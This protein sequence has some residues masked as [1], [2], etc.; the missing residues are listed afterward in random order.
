[1]KNRMS[2]SQGFTLIELMVVMVI[3][4]FLAIV[5][6]SLFF[7]LLKTERRIVYFNRMNN[8]I[9]HLFTD[10]AQDIRFANKVELQNFNP[11]AGHYEK[12]VMGDDDGHGNIIPKVIY[13]KD[14]DQIKVTRDGTTSSILNNNILADSFGFEDQADPEHL[15]LIYINIALSSPNSQNQIIKVDRESIISNINKNIKIESGNPFISITP[16]P[17]NTPRPTATATITPTPI[18]PT[19]TPSRTPT[20]TRP[21]VPTAT[22]TRFLTPTP[23]STPTPPP[24]CELV[25]EPGTW[26]SEAIGTMTQGKTNVAGSRMTICGSGAGIDNLRDGFQYAYKTNTNFEIEMTTRIVNWNP[27]EG[28]SKAGIMFRSSNDNNAAHISIFL[29]GSQGIRMQWR[30]NNGAD[31]SITGERAGN[32][33]PVWL[34]LIKIGN[35]ITGY[36]SY[37]STDGQNGTWTVVRTVDM[38]MGFNH[39]YGRAVTSSEDEQFASAIFDQTS[40]QFNA[41]IT[42]APTATPRPTNTATPTPRVTA[43]PTQRPTATPTRQVAPTSTPTQRPTATPTRIPSRTPTPT[44]SISD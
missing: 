1:M 19:S 25:D 44:S 14:G 26:R 4:A 43:T 37:N 35:T 32:N 28:W 12:I 22:P 23:T 36:F 8:S 41:S 42:P 17:T 7:Q 2:R 40:V 11:T 39:L 33:V 13:E 38:N 27:H 10:L 18:G 34:K 15:P 29:T 16:M 5:I 20:P 24:G 9:N 30:R 3:S 6:M 21:S 31:T